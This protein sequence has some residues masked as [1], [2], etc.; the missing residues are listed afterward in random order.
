M[1]F[2]VA[3][4]TLSAAKLNSCMPGSTDSARPSSCCA[5]TSPSMRTVMS[6]RGEPLASVTISTTDGVSASS[7]LYLLE[8]CWRMKPLH[9][10]C[11]HDIS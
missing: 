9:G 2:W 10:A 3:N 4:T 8:H 7:W 11:A 6:P 5:N 1:I